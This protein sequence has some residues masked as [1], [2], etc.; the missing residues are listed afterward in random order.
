MKH[1]TEFNFLSLILDCNLNWKS[2]INYISVK[3]ARVIRLLKFV[4]PK[5]VM[6]LI[7]SSLIF[8]DMN[9]WLRELSVTKLNCYKRK[10]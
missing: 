4:F 10:L 8:P 9:Y 5:Q 7:Y 6:F 3:K 1:V 2:H